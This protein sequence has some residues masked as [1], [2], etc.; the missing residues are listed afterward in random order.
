MSRVVARVVESPAELSLPLPPG[1]TVVPVQDPDDFAQAL[2][3]RTGA[4]LVGSA[5]EA[6]KELGRR[7]Q[8][9]TPHSRAAEEVAWLRGVLE[10]G[11]PELPPRL[12]PDAE[13]RSL[14]ARLADAREAAKQTRIALLKREATVQ[15]E[16]RK[17]PGV[18]AEVEPELARRVAHRVA[19]TL[20]RARAAKRALGPKP[21]LDR[22]T[23]QLARRAMS[24]LEDA[25]FAH[26][27][28][29][30]RVHTRLAVGN[31]VGLLL[32]LIGAVVVWSG[33]D[34]DA[35]SVYAVFALSG[36]API[37]A[38]AIGG[39]GA[40][41]ARRR[42]RTTSVACAQAFGRAGVQ[43]AEEL[44]R[45]RAELEDW[46]ARA[47][48]TAA[49]RDAWHDALQAWET[50]AGPDAD[51]RDVEELLEVGARLHAAKLAA[52][53]VRADAERAGRMLLSVEQEVQARLATLPAA[54][55]GTV[56]H[57][58]SPIVLTGSDGDRTRLEE[59][60]PAVPVALVTA[61]AP[62]H[63]PQSLP[64]PDPEPAPIV[65]DVREPVPEPEP[66]LEPEPE[67]EQPMARTF[68]F[69]A[70]AARRLRRRARRLR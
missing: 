25:L 12:A 11:S 46:L 9:V 24:R 31:V 66:A 41:H 61:L 39:V 68:V 26:S 4:V 70:Q 1:L 29:R 15:A 13:L 21:V 43:D 65:I 69:D 59:W 45:R 30:Q 8:S 49:A 17:S 54:T 48:A 23:E 34:L 27:R 62:V 56:V 47:D 37:T 64:E 35:P 67:P 58:T 20:R 10:G 28:A 6:Q 32:A 7:Q 57:D 22:E 16:T 44:A 33:A 42:V 3:V 14:A 63:R 52:A 55:T 5:E 18:L 19:V 51:P 36:A 38:L 50:M 53:T 60:A 2:A 40:V